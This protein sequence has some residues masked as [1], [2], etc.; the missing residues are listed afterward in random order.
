MRSVRAS[1]LY[2]LAKLNSRVDQIDAAVEAYHQIAD[3]DSDRGSQMAAEVI[4]TYQQGKEFAKAEQ[5]SEAALKKWPTDPIVRAT[6]AV[7]L[8]DMGKADAGAAEMKKLMDGKSGVQSYIT[9]AQ[10]YEKGKNFPEMEK[11]LDAA[12]KLSDAKPEKEAIYFMRGAMFEKQKKYGFTAA[13]D[14]PLM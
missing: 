8:A 3:L 7:V 5:E 9:L 2:H 11:A 1:L 12:E 13:Y 10:I 14:L 6:H 4:S